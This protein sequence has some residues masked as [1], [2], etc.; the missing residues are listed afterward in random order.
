MAI[1]DQLVTPDVPRSCYLWIKPDFRASN[2]LAAAGAATGGVIGAAIGAAADA[3]RA[4]AS[5]LAALDRLDFQFWPE[6]LSDSYQ[7][8]YAEHIIPGGTHPLYQWVAGTGR[9]ISFQAVFVSEVNTTHLTLGRIAPPEITPSRL[10]TVDVDAALN[11]LRSWQRP[12]YPDG[13]PGGLITPPARL[14]LGMPNT[15]LNGAGGDTVDV[16]LR[17][18]N[19]TIE[20]WFPNGQTRVATVDLA[21]NEIVQHGSNS[22]GSS[23]KFIDNRK[24]KEDARQNYTYRGASNL[25]LIGGL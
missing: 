18:A 12:E 23:V 13:A 14:A 5:A 1:I 16:I 21:F 25:P 22:E 10:Y 24:F 20:S 19:I 8:E 4:S 3:A 17:E 7:S 6:S 2:A 9:T 11:R 15:K